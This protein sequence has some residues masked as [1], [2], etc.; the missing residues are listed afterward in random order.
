MKSLI[1]SLFKAFFLV[2]LLF[3]SFPAQ[4]VGELVLTDTRSFALGEVH[5][6]SSDLLNPAA[7]SFAKQKSICTEVLNR[8]QMSELNTVNLSLKYPNPC[9]DMGVKL[10]TFGYEDYRMSQL[11]GSFA[12]KISDVFSMGI[13]LVYLHENSILEEKA[14]Q[15]LSAGIGFF[16]QC[17]AQLDLAVSGENLLST[18]GSAGYECHAGAQYHASENVLAL[19][20]AGYSE[21]KAFY[22]ST[23]LEYRILEQVSLRAGYNSLSQSPSLGLGYQWRN[24]VVNVGF[25]QHAVLG[26]NSMIG[27]NFTF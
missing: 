6:L 27:V 23:G 26:L 15:E 8:F 17:N 19:V 16:Y 3:R 10:A 1:P 4:A 25:A 9:L 13:Q 2:W 14:K 11:Q 20:E 18:F 7:L 24:W 21:E 12:K 22:F 5:A